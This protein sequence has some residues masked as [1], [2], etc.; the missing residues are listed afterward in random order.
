MNATQFLL[1]TFNLKAEEGLKFILL[2][3]HSFFLGIF[4]AFYFVPAN[5]NFLEHFTMNDLPEAYFA[6]GIIGYIS[7]QIYSSLQKKIGPKKL[8]LGAVLFIFVITIIARLGIDFFPKWEKEVSFF[9][10][11]WAWPFISLVAI[12]SGGLALHLL[13]LRQVKRLFGLINIGGVIASIISYLLIPIIIPLLG[14]NYDLL[15]IGAISIIVS[16]ILLLVIYK[17]FPTKR[18]GENYTKKDNKRLSMR[19]LLKEKYFALMFSSALISTIVIYFTDFGFLASVNVQD[20]LISSTEE[21]SK[22]LSI[23]FGAIKVGELIMSYFSS[24]ILSEYGIKFG[25]TSLPLMSAV[26]IGISAIVGVT[27]GPTSILFFIFNVLNK[28]FERILRRSL[29]DPSFNILYQP[30]PEEQK[31]SIQTRVGVIMQLATGIAGFLLILIAYLLGYGKGNGFKLEYFPILFFPILIVWAFISRELYNAYKEKLRQILTDRNP[32]KDKDIYGQIYGTDVLVRKLHDNN[33]KVVETSVTLLSETNPTTLESYAVSLLETENRNIIKAVLKNIDPTYPQ[34]LSELIEKIVAKEN[35]DKETKYLA[36]KALENLDYNEIDLLREDEIED[37]YTST[38]YE[39]KIFLIKYLNQNYVPNDV[40]IISKLLNDRNSK[41]KKAAIK[42]AGNRNSPVLREK[43]IEFLK[44]SEY[45]HACSLALLESGEDILEELEKLFEKETSISILL[46]IIEIFA[47][48]GSNASKSLLLSHLHYPNK[49]VQ[50]AVIRGLYFCRFQ[51]SKKD[52]HIIKEKLEEIVENILWIFVCIDEIENEKNTLKLNQSLDLERE[53][54]FHILFQLLSFLFN[55]TTID[56]IKKNIIGENT[57]FAL[58]II[59][60]FITQDIKQLI[61]PLFEN[62]SV[63]QR[64]KRL[65]TY[66]PQK[67]MTFHNRLRDI[68]TRDFNKIDLWT[69]A[70]VLELFNKIY[71]KEVTLDKKDSYFVDLWTQEEAKNLLSKIRRREIPDEIL[72]CLFHPDELVYSTAAK[73]IYDFD[74][75]RCNN[76]IKRLS[77]DKQ[78]LLAILKNKD[79]AKNLLAEKVK[80]VKRVPSYFSVPENTLVKLAKVFSVKLIRKNEIDFLIN[81]ETED[82]YIFVVLRGKIEGKDTEGEKKIFSKNATIVRGIDV[83]YENIEI[84]AKRDTLV[85]KGFRFEYFNLLT[86]ELDMLQHMFGWY[87]RSNNIVK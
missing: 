14:N 77:S 16:V 42:L 26:L 44:Y 21:R 35:I 17:K 64:I 85:L 11:I 9:T 47:K 7:T 67:K 50:V 38:T 74:E 6:S 75:A 63:S 18:K 80:L 51:V 57:I 5:S 36:N 20:T 19:A 72:I 30:L 73:I 29:D 12:E 27:S 8:F 55:P 71:K 34:D 69:K 68:I 45:S 24:Q 52:E 10:F 87:N 13:N 40:E 33:M 46:M 53:S 81:K 70:K 82:E 54:N 61:I 23:F 32:K 28:S 2:F 60:N 1:R 59:E 43:L 58:E 39:D 22:F 66:F 41:I 15:Y 25:L 37:L 31:L 83:G 3:F 79:D 4:I 78:K 49:E 65:E 84:K 86:E 48:I 76:Y 56:L 62:I